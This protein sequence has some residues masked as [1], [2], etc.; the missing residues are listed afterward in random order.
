[1]GAISCWTD[2][3]ESDALFLLIGYFTLKSILSNMVTLIIKLFKLC[4]TYLYTKWIHLLK[5][6]TSYEYRQYLMNGGTEGAERTAGQGRPLHLSAKGWP[7]HMLFASLHSL[8]SDLWCHPDWWAPPGHTVQWRRSI[9]TGAQPIHLSGVCGRDSCHSASC[10]GVGSFSLNP[11]AWLNG[12]M[13]AVRAV[14]I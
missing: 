7:G 13:C 5:S 3:I 10:L 8:S 1:M 14:H 11:T 2:V 12:L 6:V 9:Q 4:I